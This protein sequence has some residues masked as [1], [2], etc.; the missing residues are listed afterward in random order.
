MKTEAEE[1]TL[2]R[3]AK[4]HDFL[5]M[6][7]GS[8]N[9]HATQKESHAQNKQMTAVG[10]ISNPE[11][12]FRAS[13]SLFQIHGAD[14]FQWWERSS[15][16][17]PWSG[18]DLPWGR[19]Q[20]LNVRWIR[21]INHHPV[22]SDEDSAPESISDTEDWLNWNGD[23]DDPNDCEDDCAAD[24]ESDIEHDNSIE[25][26]EWPERRD[27][28]AGGTVL[29]LI[30]LTRNTERWAEKVLMTINAIETRRNKGV[31]QK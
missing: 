4:V 15:L 21:R 24:F 9:L 5:E 16:P 20:I 17:P 6:W 31:N 1:R 26:P 23:L 8:Q 29:G 14:A 27:A 7:Q 28:R 22:Q 3:M 11:E 2:H 10:Y 12:I 25:D 30:L 19:T 18:A 13:W